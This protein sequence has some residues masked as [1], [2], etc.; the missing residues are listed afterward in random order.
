[1]NFLYSTN[2]AR[3]DT[4]NKIYD[5]CFG[6]M[7]FVFLSVHQLYGTDHLVVIHRALV[8]Y[9]PDNTS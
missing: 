1:M 2:N 7:F 5:G 6:C 4:L 8:E 3:F 9:L